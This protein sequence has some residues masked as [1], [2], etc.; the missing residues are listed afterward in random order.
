[1][2]FHYVEQSFSH[3]FLLNPSFVGFA[4]RRTTVS[5]I[6]F[7]LCVTLVALQ[8]VNYLWSITFVPPDGVLLF[9]T[10]FDLAFHTFGDSTF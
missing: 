1:M 6:F 10:L 5:V 9:C 2:E 7:Y 8:R 4:A 3:R